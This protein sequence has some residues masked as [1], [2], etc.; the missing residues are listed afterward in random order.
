MKYTFP[1]CPW[2]VNDD[3]PRPLSFRRQCWLMMDGRHSYSDPMDKQQQQQHQYHH[4]LPPMSSLV[5]SERLTG[6]P[7]HINEALKQE[8]SIL[9]GRL[10]QRERLR[11]LSGRFGISQARIR[12]WFQERSEEE[13]KE[14]RLT[15]DTNMRHNRRDKQLNELEKILDNTDEIIR[16]LISE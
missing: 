11:E 13:E 8:H 1:R 3:L 9:R 14:R 5:F 12:K 2:R 6:L 10:P 7:N 4:T 16:N 15:L